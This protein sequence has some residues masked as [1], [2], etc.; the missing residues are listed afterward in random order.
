LKVETWWKK[1]LNRNMWGRIIKEAKDHRLWAR[2]RTISLPI[3]ILHMH[4]C[5]SSCVAFLL[6]VYQSACLPTREVAWTHGILNIFCRKGILRLVSPLWT[7]D[8]MKINIVTITL[9][10]FIYQGLGF[11]IHMLDVVQTI[12]LPFRVEWLRIRTAIQI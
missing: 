6:S 4:A 1:A 9:L 10:L 7:E 2:G 3:H 11:F 12:H 8:A 5:L